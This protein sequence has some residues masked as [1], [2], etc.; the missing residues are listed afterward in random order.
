MT[1]YY[2]VV[3]DNHI[4]LEGE[5]HLVEGTRVEVHAPLVGS[6]DIA[7]A[8]QQAKERLRAA[9]LLAPPPAADDEDDD[10]FQP[11]VAR[12]EAISEQII[13]ERRYWRHFI[14]TP[15]PWSNA[16]PLSQV[17]PGC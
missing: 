14:W 4:E 12:G 6:A 9:G 8:E 5:A 16:T 10:A 3:R 17:Q 11:V 7:A 13:R 15:V 2:G 1:I